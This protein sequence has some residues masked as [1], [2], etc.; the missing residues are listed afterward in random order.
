MREQ[1]TSEYYLHRDAEG[2]PLDFGAAGLDDFGRGAVRPIDLDILERVDFRGKRVLDLGCGRGEALKYAVERGAAEAHGVDFSEYAIA[3][4]RE[5]LVRYNVRAKLHHMDATEFLVWWR[6]NR[7]AAVFDIVLMLDSVEHIPRSELSLLLGVLLHLMDDRGVLAVNTPAFGADNDVLTEGLK[8]AA[9]DG[10]D[11]NEAT[12]GMHCN[13]YTKRSLKRY[14]RRQG[15]YAISHHLFLRK[16]PTRRSAQW[17]HA[18]TRSIRQAA[19]LGYPIVLPR[20]LEKEMYTDLAASFTQRIRTVLKR[21]P[22]AG[23]MLVSAARTLRRRRF[24]STSYWERRYREGG[25]SGSGSYGALA[26]FKAEVLNAF[27]RDHGISSVIELGCG[28]G[29]QLSLAAYPRYIGLDVSASAVALCRKRFAND[30]SKEFAVYDCS[31]G[32]Q[33]EFPRAELAL[34]LDVIFH[35]TE[36]RVFDAYMRALFKAATRFVIIYSDD[37]D[38]LGQSVESAVHVRHRKFSDWISANLPAWQCTQRIPNRY[39]SVCTVGGEGSWCDFWV[40]TAPS[41]TSEP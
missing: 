18:S 3:I 23:P 25:N 19:A 7:P 39:S 4:A 6:Q 37:S 2:N 13:R 29:S 20:A 22:F 40:Y 26:Q 32:G 31:T 16:W 30:L 34:S 15:F 9:S 33:G 11:E 10:G 27:V 14:M 38:T 24:S 5:F 1:Y 8:P 41:F 36:D 21:L 35:L 17:L 28:D 12:A